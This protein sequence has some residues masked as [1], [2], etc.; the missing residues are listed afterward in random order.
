MNSP[1][2][3]LRHRL[4]LLPLALLATMLAL[5]L[6][7]Q[8]ENPSVDPQALGLREPTAEEQERMRVLA[9]RVE[10]VLPNALALKRAND[11][12]AVLSLAPLALPVVPDGEE[13]RFAPATAA[14]AGPGFD[15]TPPPTAAD[16]AI[17]SSAD[18]STSQFFPP[19]RSQEQIGSC[20]C[21]AS[22]YY[23]STYMRAKARGFN[24]KND[25]NGDKLSPKFV[26]NIVNGGGDNGSWF[27]DIF[28]VLLSQGAPT[29]M[30]I[31]IPWGF[32]PAIQLLLHR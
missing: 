21:F 25:G 13:F 15:P 3:T 30:K 19:I 31:L 2:S 8:T 16:T 5:P 11:E 28:E 9:P 10:K 12:R 6:R 18:N 4:I 7:A 14:A 17:P 20:A 32:I 26:Y 29:W 23:M 1:R 22:V 24:V 27:T